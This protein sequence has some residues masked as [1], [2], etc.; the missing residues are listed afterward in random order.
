MIKNR[1]KNRAPVIFFWVAVVLVVVL[2]LA[3]I[4]GFVIARRALPK[5]DGEI[6]ISGLSAPVSVHRDADGIPHLV[7][8]KAVD[9]YLAQGYVHA[10]DRFFEMDYRRHVASGQLSELVGQNET[11]L[12]ADKV[13]RTLGWR[14]VAEAEWQI[15]D[16]Q[17]KANLSAYAAGVNAY[18]GS[19]PASSVALEYVVLGTTVKVNDIKKWDPIDSL[20]WLKAMAWDLNSNYDA[21]LT[22]AETFGQVKDLG[23]VSELFPP[24]PSERNAP[25]NTV[26]ILRDSTAQE[27]TE[28]ESTQTATT[29][30]AVTTQNTATTDADAAAITTALWDTKSVLQTVPVLVG[31][32][33]GTG[34]NSWA[35]S[36]DLTES[37]KPLLANDPHL[38]LE[39]P[40][41]WYQNSLTCAEINDECPSSVSGFSLSGIPGVVIGHNDDLA[42]GLT[43]MGADVSDFFIERTK[44]EEYLRDGQWLPLETRTET[45]KVN[46]GK[47]VEIQV[48]STVHG[49]I[50]SD[51]LPVEKAAQN[52]VTDA[53]GIG[54]RYAISLGWTALEPGHTAAAIFQLNNAKTAADVIAAAATFEVPA[55]NIIFATVSGD[56]GVQAPGKVPLR[57]EVSGS[58]TSSDGSWPRPGW[59][60]RYDWQGYVPS[61]DMPLVMNPKEGYIVAANQ[62][63]QTSDYGLFLTNDWDYG[64]RSQRIRTLLDGKISQHKKLTVA[65]MKEIQLDNYNPLAEI[66][67]PQLLAQNIPDSFDRAGQ[68]LLRN[69]NF[70]QD[71]DSAE[72]GYF[73]AVWKHLLD[74][75]FAD[76]LPDHALP[77]DE[78]RWVEVITNLL[79]DPTSPWWDDRSTPHIVET[80]DEILSQ[81]LIGARHDLTAN[82]GS[83]PKDWQWGKMHKFAGRHAVLGGDGVPTLV[84]SIFNPDPVALSGGNYIVN[85]TAWEASSGNYLATSGPSMR[86]VVDLADFDHST[87]IVSGGVS[88]HLVSGSYLNQMQRWAE[89]KYLTWSYTKKSITKAPDLLQLNP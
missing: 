84:R 38:S 65:D 4:S 55:Q 48:R 26:S 42:W 21:E 80:R 58:A 8:E 88:G 64:Y 40:G 24:Y 45:I 59:D 52:P 51:V 2:L 44:N 34:S 70:Q 7:G 22:R 62:A 27:S 47:D 19:R 71:A 6:K 68:D 76:E 41:V 60:S 30:S 53:A 67:V 81:A 14:Q 5:I 36:G 3:F 63:W 1:R 61:A 66:L 35:V 83:N 46:G 56:I 85:A 12:N 33:Q 39:I 13:V 82:L 77:R 17:T 43:N 25:I 75:T 18:L 31:R 73:S 15:L 37:G 28:T 78:S 74:L 23:K 49:P 29:E 72:A 57:A 86:M 20:V 79:N 16:P 54:G 89:G 9:L 10:Q 69:W 50:V 32:G 87:W 11:A